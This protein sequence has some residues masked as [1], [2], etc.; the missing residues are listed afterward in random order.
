MRLRVRANGFDLTR[1]MS[2]LP[3]PICISCD[4][5]REHNGDLSIPM[6]ILT[7]PACLKFDVEIA[8]VVESKN[9]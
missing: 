8:I 7:Y 3:K 1:D 5:P 2:Q 4:G 6:L 9:S